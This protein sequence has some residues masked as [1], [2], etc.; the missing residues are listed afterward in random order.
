MTISKNTK[1]VLKGLLGDDPAPEVYVDDTILDTPEI[2]PNKKYQKSTYRFMNLFTGL[3]RAYGLY[4]NGRAKTLRQN[5][6]VEKYEWHLTGHQGIGIGVVPIDEDNMCRFGVIDIDIDDIDHQELVRKVETLKLP[7]IVCRSKS[8]GAHLYTFMSKPAPARTVRKLLSKWA[9]DLGHGASEIFPK[10]NMLE[11][12]TVGNWINLPYFNMVNEDSCNRYGFDKSGPMVFMKFLDAAE[13][14]A[15]NN[16][17]ENFDDGG[18]EPDGMPPCLSYFFHSGAGE[19]CRNEVLYSMGVFA[20]KADHPD[21][22]EFLF[23]MNFKIID[24]P[25]PAREVKTILTSLR[26]QN[27]QYKCKHP[28][29]KQYCNPEVCKKLKHGIVPQVIEDE[30]NESMMG[31]LTKY[32]TDP[33]KWKLDVN[34]TDIYFATDELMNYYRVRCACMER[35]SIIVPPMKQEEWLM[36]LKSRLDH[37][38]IVEAPDDASEGGDILTVLSEFI[39]ISERSQAGREDLLRGIPI[40]DTVVEGGEDVPV[41]MFRSQDFLVYLKRRKITLNVTGNLLW[42]KMRKLG[43]GHAKIRFKSNTIQVW[44]VPMSPDYTAIEPMVPELEI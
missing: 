15:E 18:L 20:K 32:T 7:L 3:S 6:T 43:V 27:Y 4:Q 14:L 24:P 36:L 12:N 37:V 23:Q 11:K 21:I 19:G 31:C 2:T 38:K 17:I 40:K 22:E 25:L 35:A 39:Q 16:D 28:M 33:V 42:M 8:G 44:Y 1:D 41:I 29:F 30:Y 13:K 5:I 10:Q 26:R 34:G 9:A